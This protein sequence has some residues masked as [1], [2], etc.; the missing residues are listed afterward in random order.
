MYFVPVDVNFHGHV[1]PD[2]LAKLWENPV[3]LAF[4]VRLC[5]FQIKLL[6][7][8][9]RIL[10]FTAPYAIYMKPKIVMCS[11]YDLISILEP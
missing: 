5:R 2:I 11:I 7:S 1:D 10:M 6:L 4:F 9:W 3:Q 8:T